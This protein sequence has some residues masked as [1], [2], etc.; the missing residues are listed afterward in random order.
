MMLYPRLALT[1]IKKNRQ[2]Y[3]PYILTCSGMIMI[4]Y[5]VSFLSRSEQMKR[6][7][8]G[9]TMV[10]LLSLGCGVMIVFS[11]IFL[12]Y[13]NSFLVK[14]RTKEFG[15][16]NVL[17][18]GKRNIAKIM[19][20]ETLMIYAAG[21]V[22]GCGC[23]ILFSKLAELF[24]KR[25]MFAETDF[26]FHVD[27]ASVFHAIIWFGIIFV[28]ILINSLLRLRISDPLELLHSENTGERPPKANWIP[29]VIGA[30]LLGFS[31][32]LAVV[33]QNPLSAILIFFFAVIMVM[34]ATYLLFIAGSVVFCK[35]LR[36]N[37]NYYY[38][39]NHFVS[40]SQMIYRMK[41]NGAG[42][43]SICILS[44]MVLVTMSTTICL[45]AGE[46]NIVDMT[47]PND[48]TVTLISTN[49]DIIGSAREIVINDA[50]AENAV[51]SD[52]FTYRFA[53]FSAYAD[54]NTMTLTAPGLD[55]GDNIYEI[56][57]VPIEDYNSITGKD[58]FLEKNQVLIYSKS[59]NDDLPSVIFKG[60]REFRIIGK[61]D[62]FIEIGGAARSVFQTVYFFMDSADTI[63]EIRDL[64]YQQTETYSSIKTYCGFD[65]D[66]SA[67]VKKAVSEKALSDLTAFTKEHADDEGYGGLSF[68]SREM[69]RMDFYSTYGGLFFLGILLGSV[70]V[71]AAVLIMYY[72]QV[73]EGY[74]DR[75]RFDILKKVGMSKKEI[76]QSINSQVLT[77][78]FLPL[79]AAGVHMIF[80]FP[81]ISR[82]LRVF[83]MNDASLFAV[84]TLI[85]FGVFALFYTA[86]YFI[87]SRSYYKIA[88]MGDD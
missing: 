27:L 72:K 14:R 60:I 26:S 61:A 44:T 81:I 10:G 2:T 86:A 21:I 6:L 1:G 47:F 74:E 52:E 31:Y 62:E 5:I 53:E 77:V 12:Y 64:C 79:A 50:N 37:K 18:M 29:A 36:S 7:E 66:A 67:S 15:L 58:V 82:M 87:T 71:V 9:S 78:F 22:T 68:D 33:I 76:R 88:A 46:E 4:Y 51:I 28:L 63:R 55:S 83:G 16:Y 39:T 49:R 73:S 20:W 34:I 45:Y 59:L 40:V 32:Y 54:Q 8:G 30:V 42:L 48:I 80:A 41:R 38:K 17:G 69:N 13:T 43:A 56:Y 65:L 25:I 24:L 35:L 11:G 85:C 57:F 84:I 70:F 3:I 23:G 19:I 75:S